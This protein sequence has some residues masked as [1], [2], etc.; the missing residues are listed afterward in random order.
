[1]RMKHLVFCKFLDKAAFI[2]NKY[3]R[4]HINNLLFYGNHTEV[5]AFTPAN[6]PCKSDASLVSSMLTECKHQRHCC[7]PLF[8]LIQTR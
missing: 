4:G 5:R 6:L 7:H 1:M 8:L 2:D 3:D